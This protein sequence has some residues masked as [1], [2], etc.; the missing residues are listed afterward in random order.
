[1]FLQEAQLLQLADGLVQPRLVAVRPVVAGVE[2]RRGVP[3]L[4]RQD[5]RG[6]GHTGEQANLMLLRDGEEV[7]GGLLLDDAVDDLHRGAV[8]LTHEGVALFEPADVRTEGGAVVA[9]LALTH[10]VLQG[11][12]DLVAFYGGDAGVVQLVE[13]DVVRVE[14]A[15]AL[16]AGVADEVRRKVLGALAVAL[17][18]DCVVDVVAELGGIH[19]VVPVGADGLGEDLLAEALAVGVRGV[20][21][22]DA[23]AHGLLEELDTVS[24]LDL[25]P[26]V[27]CD[28]PDAEAHLGHGQVGHP[29]LP[30]LH[31]RSL[32]GV[33]ALAW[34]SQTV[35]AC[36]VYDF[37]GVDGQLRGVGASSKAKGP[38]LTYARRRS[39]GTPREWG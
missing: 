20:E 7:A 25:T 31:S 23:K 15:E 38:T 35:S 8:A 36:P 39:F 5:L 21:E 13:V 22:G 27:G 1:M 26:P 16:L 30:V 33:F 4:L 18:R 3:E 29:K 11:V 34:M 32:S 6:M 12:E 10:K 2:D 17:S 28:G 9:H 24:G 19:H 37:A 14:A